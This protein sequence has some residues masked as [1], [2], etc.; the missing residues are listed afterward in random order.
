MAKKL[1]V[2]ELKKLYE[3]RWKYP[4]TQ[5]PPKI[6][7]IACGKNINYGI[8]KTYEPCWKSPMP[9]T[10]EAQF[11]PCWDYPPERYKRRPLPPPCRGATIPPDLLVP[12][13]EHCKTVY[14]RFDFRLEECVHQQI[15]FLEHLF[16][17]LEVQFT[18]A[19]TF[20]I[21][22][23]KRMRYQSIRRRLLIG[24]ACGIKIYPEYLSQM[25]EKR[26]LCDFQK[27]H[28]AIKQSK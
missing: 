25:A 11:G 26:A 19:R 18:D 28:N 17:K 4:P 15:L 5:K 12:E 3:E 22:M 10:V 23:A 24:S 27:A 6:R 20:Q 14:T 21:E 13:F 16:R 2:S 8:E 7:F 9:M 1:K